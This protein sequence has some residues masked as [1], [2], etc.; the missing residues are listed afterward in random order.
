[1]FLAVLLMFALGLAV[2]IASASAN[3][4]LD[5]LDSATLPLAVTFGAQGHVSHFGAA[6]WSPV[7]TADSRPRRQ[8][9]TWS[10]SSRCMRPGQRR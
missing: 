6:E 7:F 4:I 9:P 1:M 10:S 2:G 8:V 3:S 5:A